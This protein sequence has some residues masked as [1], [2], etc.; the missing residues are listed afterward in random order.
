MFYERPIPEAEVL[1]TP[2]EAYAP[3]MAFLEQHEVLS[4]SVLVTPSIE[5]PLSFGAELIRSAGCVAGFT[6]RL[7][8]GV[9]GKNLNCERGGLGMYFAQGEGNHAV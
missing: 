1:A 9:L 7:T 5:P 6:E 3:T 4:F 2:E 8:E